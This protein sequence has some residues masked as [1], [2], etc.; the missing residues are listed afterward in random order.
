MLVK[1]ITESDLIQGVGVGDG[2]IISISWLGG[3]SKIVSI[4]IPL[5]LDWILRD[6]IVHHTALWKLIGR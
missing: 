2:D 6:I 4:F 3:V 5:L 1:A